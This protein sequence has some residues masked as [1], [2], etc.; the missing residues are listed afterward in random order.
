LPKDL[1][2][3]HDTADCASALL[4]YAT[5]NEAIDGARYARGGGCIV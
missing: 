5:R 4:Q 2:T 3:G 1:P